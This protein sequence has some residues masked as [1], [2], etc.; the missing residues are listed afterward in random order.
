MPGPF[1]W[2]LVVD[3]E[4]YI[5]FVLA[6]YLGGGPLVLK[7][8]CADEALVAMLDAPEGEPG[9]ALVD[10]KMPGT[11]GLATI[12]LLRR[13]RPGLPCVLVTGSDISEEDALAGGADSLLRKPF[14]WEDLV[15]CLDSLA[16]RD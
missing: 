8:S 16:S 1:R 5:R 12:A 4:E 15:A 2:F 14:G 11:D 10:L 13:L 9:C 6:A 7:A 3:D